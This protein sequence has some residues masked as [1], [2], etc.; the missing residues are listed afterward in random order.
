MSDAVSTKGM[1]GFAPLSVT[2]SAGSVG[3][4]LVSGKYQISCTGQNVYVRQATSQTDALTVTAPAGS[5]RGM[6]VF[7]GNSVDWFLDAGDYLGFVTASG[8]ATV[9]VHWARGF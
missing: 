9:N 2:T 6:E 8:A 4:I 7:G 5:V 1:S 3:P